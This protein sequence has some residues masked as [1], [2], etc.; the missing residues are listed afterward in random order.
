MS[1]NSDTLKTNF[2]VPALGANKKWWILGAIVAVLVLW[3]VSSYNGLVT[4]R[5][6]VNTK[7]SAVESDY[8]RRS[9][10]VPNLVSTVKGAAN[11]EQDTL[12]KVIEAR[13]KATQIKV[14]PS[15]AADIQKFQEAQGELSSTL[16]RLLVVSEQYP[17]LQAVQ[18]FR[19]LQVQLEG[20]EN[21]ISVARKDF[22]KAAQ[23]YNVKIG[24]F[25]TN[26]VAGIFGFDKRAYFEAETGTDKSPTVDFGSN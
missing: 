7:W 11:F 13:S 20:T 4:S 5:E 6:A 24:K 10:L 16:S 21:R 2:K 14:D 17:Q 15:N 8:Q 23:E 22:S 25:P 19:D 3:L 12:T 26:I 18:A 9:D 1:Q